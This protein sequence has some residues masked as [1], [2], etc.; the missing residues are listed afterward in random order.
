[1]KNS[2]KLL[3]AVV[4]G[5]SALSVSAAQIYNKNDT[6]LDV[7]GYVD[8]VFWSGHTNQ[9]KGANGDATIVSRTR[10]G[11]QGRA[12]I[13]GNIYGLGKSGHQLQNVVTPQGQTR[14]P[15]ISGLA[16]TSLRAALS[17]PA[18]TSTTSTGLTPSPIT[19]SVQA[20]AASHTPPVTAAN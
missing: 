5:V 12:K 3:A 8:A 18:V 17:R 14:P 6:T 13:A 10:S 15:V 19:L 11:L 1:M 7:T 9:V 2:I 16:L 20:A 4:A